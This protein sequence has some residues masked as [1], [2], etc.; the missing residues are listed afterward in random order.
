MV[1][2]KWDEVVGKWRVDIRR[3]S[4]D[5]TTEVFEDS[6]DLLFTGLG[7]LSRWNWPDIEG[8]NSF[9]GMLIHSAKWEVPS[10]NEATTGASQVRRDWVEDVKDWGNKRVAVIGVVRS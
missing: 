10:Q 4:S 8:L 5:G 2:A 7:L 9:K 1:G 3:P 6:A